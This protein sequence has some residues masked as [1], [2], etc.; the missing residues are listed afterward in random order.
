M[1]VLAINGRQINV[2]GIK[3]LKSGVSVQEAATKTKKNGIDEVYFNVSGVN[4]LAYGDALDLK[5]LSK[6]KISSITYNNQSGTIVSYEDEIN[7][8]GEGITSGALN[9]LKKTKEALFG[10]VSNTITSVGPTGV[11]LAGGAIGLTGMALFRGG[12]AAASATVGG[13]AAAA[14]PL[15]NLLG[16][17]L[18]NGS[19]GALKVI[20]VAGAIGFGLTAAAG[21][22]GGISEALSTE[23]DYSTIASITK[24]GN[25]GGTATAT[26]TP[27]S[28]P[29]TPVTEPVNTV[30]SPAAP[31]NNG[32]TMGFGT[33]YQASAF[34]TPQWNPNQF[35]AVSGYLSGR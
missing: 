35:N 4:Y 11:L 19:I 10:A 8:V 33:G 20:T 21:A 16:D 7:S 13:I 23:K 31:V 32:P 30:T 18:K 12:A 6:N 9:G 5:E 26:T 15:G 28:N 22:I 2:Q 17:I 34:G 27:V 3:E 24:D 1:E 14:S 29:V 25:A